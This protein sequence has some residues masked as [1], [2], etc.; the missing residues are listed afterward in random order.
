[1]R[2]LKQKGILNM[3]DFERKQAK[4]FKEMLE[5]IKNSSFGIVQIEEHKEP[6]MEFIVEVGMSRYEKL[7]ACEEELK[8]LKQALSM[9]NA[10]DLNGVLKIFGIEKKGV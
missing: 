1:M 3:R 7:I 10:Y 2:H 5:E 8:L 9:I 4:D 6:E